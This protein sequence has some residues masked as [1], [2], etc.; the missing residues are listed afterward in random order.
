MLGEAITNATIEGTG[1][2]DRVEGLGL[3]PVTTDSAN[4]DRGTRP[5]KY[6]GR[7]PTLRGKRNRRG[8]RD[9]HRR[10]DADGAAARPIDGDGAGTRWRSWSPS[11]RPRQ[12]TRRV[13]RRTP[14]P[15]VLDRPRRRRRREPTRPVE[16]AAGLI[17]DHVD[18]GPLGLS[19]QSGFILRNPNFMR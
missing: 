1:D 18:L 11:P 14:P 3:L 5:A 13:L 10:L 2:A 15:R 19:D 17:T 16:R 7:R 6:R 9:S 4:R 12:P 8:L